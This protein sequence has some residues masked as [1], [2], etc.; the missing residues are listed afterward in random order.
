MFEFA[1]YLHNLI[2]TK[3][4]QVTDDLI[5]QLIQAESGGDKL[6]EIELL[7]M[8]FLL[9]VAGHETTVNLI[10][11]STL[12]LLQ[13]P[14]QRKL[15]QENPELI[16]SAIEEFLRF[17][18]PVGMSTNRWA[19]EDLE[20]GGHQMRRGDL[21]LISLAGANHDPS[22]FADPDSLDITRPEN[23]HLAFG[24]GIHYCLGAPLAR[25]EGQ[26]AIN[27]L[28]RRLPDLRLAVSPEELVWRPSPLLL[29]LSKLPVTF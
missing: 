22:E 8:I 21:V 4:E 10:G 26:I 2:A 13:H 14:D 3:R 27:T 18:S 15:L 29:G 24:M 25:L 17:H 9:L 11:N 16:K 6:N 12:A 23:R 7:A 28:L 20:F 19:G 5:G 1:A